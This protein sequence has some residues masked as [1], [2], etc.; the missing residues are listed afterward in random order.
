MLSLRGDIL[1]LG[2]GRVAIFRALATS[3]GQR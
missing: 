1:G 2:N 3:N